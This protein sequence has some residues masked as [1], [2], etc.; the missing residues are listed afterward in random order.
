MDN[1]E[2]LATQDTQDEDKQ[3]KTKQK[4]N[5]ICVGHHYTP[6]NVKKTYRVHL[7][8]NGVRTHNFSGD[9]GDRH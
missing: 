8:M 1:P 9:S 6:N 2:K 7:A 3:N 4:H 5:T